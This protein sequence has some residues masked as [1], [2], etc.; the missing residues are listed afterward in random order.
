M[1]CPLVEIERG[2]GPLFKTNQE[3]IN[4]QIEYFL[5]QHSYAMVKFA[6]DIGSWF[7]N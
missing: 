4:I 3:T 2:G 5:A 1:H 7:L 6:Y